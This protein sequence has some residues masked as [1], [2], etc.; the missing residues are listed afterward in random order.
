MLDNKEVLENIDEINKTNTTENMESVNVE[1]KNKECKAVET[2][3]DNTKVASENT[4]E[5]KEDLSKDWT[6]LGIDLDIKLNE[7]DIWLFSMYHAN[8]GFLGFF[9]L[10]FTSVSIFYLIKNFAILAPSRRLLF[11]FCALMFTV[12]QPTSLYIKAKKQAKNKYIKE[13]IHIA[14]FGEGVTVEQAGVKGDFAW[15]NVYKTAVSKNMLIIYL[16]KA[17]AYL[18]PK[19]YYDDNYEKILKVLSENT[20]IEKNISLF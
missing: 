11:V 15:D 4:Q 16:S 13:P 3:E 5:N 20:K 7:K 12:I 10:L 19:R 8:K 18:I 2:L 1:C 6:N 14:I 17:R 9:N